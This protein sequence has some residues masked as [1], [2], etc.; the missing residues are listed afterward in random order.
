MGLDRRGRH[1]T[2][3]EEG[4][5]PGGDGVDHGRQAGGDGRA[6]ERRHH[7]GGRRRDQRRPRRVVDRDRRCGHAARG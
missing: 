4:G 3:N 2:R 5:I 6:D 1:C 7:G